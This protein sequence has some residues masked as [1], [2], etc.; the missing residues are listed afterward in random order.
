[1]PQAQKQEGRFRR[2]NPFL[3]LLGLAL[4]AGVR[5]AAAQEQWTYIQNDSI[6]LGVR[7]DFGAGI[8]Y[9]AERPG[10][11][12]LLNHA[13]HG[14]LI[15]QS[16]YGDPD[17]STWNGRPW[18]WNPVQGGCWNGT[19]SGAVEELR[20]DGRTLY[21][22]TRPVNWG[23]CEEI[24]AVMEQWIR[25]AGK[26]AHVRFRFRNGARDNQGAR[27]QE[28]P[29]V[30]MDYALP[31]LAYYRGGKPWTGGPLTRR[32]PAM[33][34]QYDTLGEHWAAYVDD[35]DRGAGVYSPGTSLMTY[36]RFAGD[37]RTGPRGGAC[38]YFAPI[39]TLRIGR[40]LVLEYDVYLYVGSLAPMRAE[41]RHI[42]EKGVPS[43]PYADP[44]VSVRARVDGPGE[45]P[46][47][48]GP[49][50]TGFSWRAAGPAGWGYSLSG[51]RAK[52]RFRVNA[53]GL[54]EEEGKGLP[55]F[56]AGKQED[57]GCQGGGC[58][59]PEAPPVEAL[60]PERT[61][62]ARE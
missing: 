9:L 5:E 14:R 37:G 38:S 26:V 16:Y 52:L 62:G 61:R 6:R 11:R 20:S 42:R 39:R 22:R 21:A 1:M 34:N 27:H 40:G 19:R 60:D 10:D 3:A 7:A 4:A 54:S 56:R 17:G 43:S 15:Q 57:A 46:A 13:D 35:G 12:N 2:A 31:D 28:M 59:G 58:G 51:R 25:L 45:G 49:N 44:G 18:T 30:F 29:A 41:F 32:T 36:Y 8:A 50:R 48:Q 47:A 23:S 33:G 55:A 24:D 53:S